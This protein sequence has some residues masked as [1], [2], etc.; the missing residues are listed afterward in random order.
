MKLALNRD[1]FLLLMATNGH[2]TTRSIATAL[3]VDHSTVSRLLNGRNGP[4]GRLLAAFQQ[5]FPSEPIAEYF[6]AA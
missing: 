4:G 2:T 1:L 3:G 5:K 6:P